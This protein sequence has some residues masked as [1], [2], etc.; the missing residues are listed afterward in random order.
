M[1]YIILHTVSS[2]LSRALYC[3][4]QNKK[5]P[6]GFEVNCYQLTTYIVLFK[7]SASIYNG[8]FVSQ[9]SCL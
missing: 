8:T 2:N 6:V 9:S 1:L 4:I 7:Y 3:L 5:Y